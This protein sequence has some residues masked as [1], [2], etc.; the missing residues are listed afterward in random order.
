MSDLNRPVI[1]TASMGKEDFAWADGLRRLHFPP[2]RNFLSAH[3]TL[4]HH[5]PP[6]ALPEI[7]K[8]VSDLCRHNPKPVA[9][10]SKLIH[11][12]RGVAFQVRCPEL[13]EMRMELAEMFHG[14]LVAQ[15]QQ[16]P[17]LHI[18]V[19]NK[20][21]PGEAKE[22][23]KNLEADFAP[24]PFEITGL[25]L[26]YYMDGPWRDIGQWPFRGR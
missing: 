20:V 13:V 3:I 11:L 2:E 14:L 16:R 17:R 26:H 9:E 1:M 24:R 25:A 19:Q 15:D 18:T 23:L 5:L 8:A 12:G 21:T 4:F 7:R 22:L 6:Q 10:L